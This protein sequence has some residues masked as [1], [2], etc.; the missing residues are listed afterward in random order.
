MKF[1]KKEFIE[2]SLLIKLKNL[3][4]SLFMISIV[5]IF[6]F[7]YYIVSYSII[8]ASVLIFILMEDLGL[9]FSDSVYDGSPTEPSMYPLAFYECMSI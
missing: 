7:D 9:F 6:F 4:F 8:F 5:G 2:A 1:L 3:S